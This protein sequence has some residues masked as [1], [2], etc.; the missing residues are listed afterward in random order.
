MMTGN[1]NTFYRPGDTF[2]H[3]VDPR[4][5]LCACLLVVVVIF[6]AGNWF[7]L[8][9]PLIALVLAMISLAPLPGSFWRVCWMLR[10]LILFTLL[11]HLL[12][13]DGRTLLGTSWL[14]LDG[15]YNGLHVSLQM[16][17]AV[18]AATVLSI[19]TSV[20]ELVTAFGWFVR[21]LQWLGCKTDEWQTTLLLTIQLVP[22]VHGEMNNARE[23]GTDRED[24]AS[25]KVPRWYSMGVLFKSFVD[26]LLTKGDKVAHELVAE[27]HLE[28]QPV[29]LPGLLP[30]TLQDQLFAAS[31]GLLVLIYGL[32]G[33]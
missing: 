11:M 4:L 17:M 14:S 20:K 13:T 22:V 8:A 29:R 33:M 1:E 3:S 5:K 2:L 19:S 23:V 24:E 31:C 6:A 26:G 21:P 18:V 12:F 10:W 25:E 7:Q 30:L 16:T 32:V 15:L 28:K 9:L 27:Q